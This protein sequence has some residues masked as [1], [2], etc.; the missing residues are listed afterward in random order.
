MDPLLCFSKVRK[1]Y[2]QIEIIY[3]DKLQKMN[4]IFKSPSKLMFL[5]EVCATNG[6]WQPLTL[7]RNESTAKPTNQT[8]KQIK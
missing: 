6:R 3:L 2:F 8:R 4:R 7:A 1:H 5:A